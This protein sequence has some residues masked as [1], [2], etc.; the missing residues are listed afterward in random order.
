M[1]ILITGG[2]GFIGSQLG[3]YFNEMEWDTSYSYPITL[4]DNLSYGHESNAVIKD[5][6]FNIV[7]DDV[8][9]NSIRKHV[10][11]ADYIIHCAGIA[12]LPD[13]QSNPQQTI[14]VNVEGTANILELA[15]RCSNV[16]RIVFAS[17]SAVYENNQKFPAFESDEVNPDL[18][19]AMSK[20][21]A[22]MLCKSYASVYNLPV[23]ILRF[24]NVYGPS[25]DL[26]RKHPALTSY[27]IK[28]L[29]DGERPILHSDGEQ[30]R[31]YVYVEDLCKLVSDVLFKTHKNGSIINVCSNKTYSVKE[32]YNTIARIMET[33]IKPVYREASKMWDKY[34]ELINRSFPISIQRLNKEVNKYAVGSFISARSQFG[35][36]PKTSLEDGLRKTVEY[37]KN[38]IKKV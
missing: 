27:I 2:L 1:N 19:Y 24:F 11:R 9:N 36:K 33:N 22:E 23:T 14:S 5:R 10:E 15:S 30:R 16:K 12:P 29:L 28:S 20:L 6:P 38:N 34:T 32:I 8:R 4:L 26:N 17:T 37:T 25:Q 35:W 31:D 3:Q 21:Q 7:I 18:I 13:C